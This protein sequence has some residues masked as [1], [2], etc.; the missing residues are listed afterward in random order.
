MLIQKIKIS[1]FDVAPSVDTTQVKAINKRFK[2]ALLMIIQNIK[3]I[4]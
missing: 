4:I 3:T 2:N 1:H